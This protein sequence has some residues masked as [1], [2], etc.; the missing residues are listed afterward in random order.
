MNI[1]KLQ[2]SFKFNKL[3]FFGDINSI[4][5]LLYGN[6]FVLYDKNSMPTFYLEL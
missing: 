1:F 5:L 3:L 6:Q 2:R 4:S